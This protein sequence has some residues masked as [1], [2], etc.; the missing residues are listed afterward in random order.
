[1]TGPCTSLFLLVGLLASGCGGDA[2]LT[3]RGSGPRRP[4]EVRIKTAPATFVPTRIVD[5]PTRDIAALVHAGLVALDYNTGAA[6]V[7]PG[8]AELPQVADRGDRLSLS[9]E[10]RPVRFTD[11]S[12]VTAADVAYSFEAVLRS[13]SP[14]AFTLHAIIGAADFEASRSDG[15][16]G[17]RALGPASFELELAPD[18]DVDGFLFGLA[19]GVNWIVKRG[20]LE[21]TDL[22]AFDHGIVGAGPYVLGAFEPG[23][24]YELLGRESTES[25][26]PPGAPVLRF[27][28]IPDGSAAGA[29]QRTGE[30]DVV[31]LDDA[32]A[33][34]ALLDADG[35]PPPGSRLL[36]AHAN[37][38][39]YLLWNG[40][41]D[42]PVPHET[43]RSLS[44]GLRA[45]LDTA[46][47]AASVYAHGLA[48]GAS[49]NQWYPMN[50]VARGEVRND[51]SGTGPR[52]RPAGIRL[53]HEGSSYNTALAELVR[54]SLSASD[55]EVML[56]AR[57]FG[58]WI[59]AV[60]AGDFDATIMVVEANMYGPR[61]WA[62]LFDP[63]SGLTAFGAP[64]S[65]VGTL[66]DVTGTTDARWNEIERSIISSGYVVPLL[67]PRKAF[68]VR[69]TVIGPTTDA[70]GQVLF[71]TLRF[72]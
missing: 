11:G 51:V 49:L 45:K 38:L 1:M 24:S 56:D 61:F 12:P 53:V 52:T 10:L 42:S 55:V 43:V 35:A 22:G 19:C 64:L 39:V 41:A 34:S 5:V 48:T 28:V 58:E 71:S 27:T 23:R 36:T 18:T 60:I 44:Q 6:R 16:A 46:A 21:R 20:E 3:E 9:F 13:Q 17:F 70:N 69:D 30:V 2:R 40:R 37:R 50:F 15:L 54:D 72:R 29:A 8:L 65:S 14:F 66:L 7:L 26:L 59:G 63:L 62:S 67:V 47:I 33:V 68:V 32:A 25:A 4:L 57:E 31:E